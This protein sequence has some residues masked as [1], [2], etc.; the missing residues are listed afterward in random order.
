MHKSSQL[1]F[2][3]RRYQGRIE[4]NQVEL[5]YLNFE[6][7]RHEYISAERAQEQSC[8]GLG[9]GTLPPMIN[10]GI[11]RAWVA[12]ASLYVGADAAPSLP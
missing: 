5:R 1:V 9:E 8:R 4:L 11:C 6:G 3:L 2:Y 7:A 10:S 12:T